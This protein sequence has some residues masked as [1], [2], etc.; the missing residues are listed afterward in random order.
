MD[1]KNF[2]LAD[3]KPYEKNPRKNDSAVDAVANSIEQFGFKVPIVIDSDNII[4]CGHTRY[5]AAQKLGLE[6]VPCV[7]ADDLSPEQIKAFRLADNKVAE[8]SSWDFRGLEFELGELKDF[9]LD[10]NNFGFHLSDFE[11]IDDFF[12]EVEPKGNSAEPPKNKTTEPTSER[13]SPDAETA[14]PTVEKIEDTEPSEHSAELSNNEINPNK[15]I[16]P[17]CGRTFELC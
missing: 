12:E 5:K 8:L 7:V 4:V 13:K 6:S 10:M 3:L 9:G 16:C 1:V 17:H 14:E 11:S 15:I 2:R